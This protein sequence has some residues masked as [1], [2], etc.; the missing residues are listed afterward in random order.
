MSPARKAEPAPTVSA[1]PGPLDDPRLSSEAELAQIQRWVNR[2]STLLFVLA[3]WETGMGAIR[4]VL[5][6]VAPALVVFGAAVLGAIAAWLSYQR[7]TAAFALSLAWTV[8]LVVLNGVLL[9]RL[10]FVPDLVGALFAGGSAWVIARDRK[11]YAHVALVQAALLIGDEPPSRPLWDD[12]GA[13]RWQRYRGGLRHAVF[14][15]LWAFPSLMALLVWTIAF[16][17][18]W[19][20][21]LSRMVLQDLGS[22][23]PV[24][25]DDG[26]KGLAWVL[27]VLLAATITAAS[28][29]VLLLPS[30]L[31]VGSM[32]GGGFEFDRRVSLWT[33]GW[34]MLTVV[35]ATLFQARSLVDPFQSQETAGPG[36]GAWFWAG[37]LAATVRKPMRAILDRITITVFRPFEQER[38]AVATAWLIRTISAFGNARFIANDALER[39]L[40]EVHGPGVISELDLLSNGPGEGRIW[41]QRAQEMIDE[42]TFVLLDLSVYSDNLAWE[43]ARVEEALGLDHCLILVAPGKGAALTRFAQANPGLRKAIEEGHCPVFELGE[44]TRGRLKLTAL[45]FR[46]T[47]RART[48]DARQHAQR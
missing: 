14:G 28:A 5:G 41:R 7:R 33:V 47:L 9:A 20:F 3:F 19:T 44:G 11:R 46:L 24:L 34:G 30:V 12:D 39:G 35:A 13:R 31:A 37:A 22:R 18:T 2:R 26:L 21:F 4:L 48:T 40:M 45:L 43:V 16:L 10:V 23:P 8:G 36:C 17:A 1:T 25:L 29:A 15:V 32:A 6:D 27:L 38:T 42:S